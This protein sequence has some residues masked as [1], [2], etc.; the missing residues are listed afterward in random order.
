MNEQ[1]VANTVKHY[2]NQGANLLDRETLARLQ[3]AR[4]EALAHHVEPK[5]VFSLAWSSHS[6]TAVRHGGHAG[7]RLWVP[8]AV[9]LALLFAIGYFHYTETGSDAGEIDALLLAD[10][11]PVSAYLD[12]RFD[13]WLRRSE[14]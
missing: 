11:L 4:N 14:H 2:L 5:R 13:T 7:A 9:L 6:G 12:H 3:N 10:D 1:R 8:F